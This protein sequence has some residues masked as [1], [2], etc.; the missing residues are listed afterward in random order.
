MKLQ[1]QMDH[2][3]IIRDHTSEDSEEDDAKTIHIGTRVNLGGISLDLL[4]GG[5]AGSAQ[6]HAWR[7]DGLQWFTF[8]PSR[9]GLGPSFI[10]F[11][12]LER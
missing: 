12:D 7:R 5:E 11:V 10:P 8:K 3:L 4:G 1:D 9:R 6:T 2:C